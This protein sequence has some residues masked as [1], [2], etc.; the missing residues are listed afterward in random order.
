[1]VSRKMSNN[2][3][4]SIRLTDDTLARADR[5]VSALAS[6]PELSAA[7]AQVT[8]STVLRLAL[9]RGLAQL[10]Q[11][12]QQNQASPA[13]TRTGKAAPRRR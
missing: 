9:L 4:T 1:M 11:E 10:E 5:L 8:R 6:E 3:T 2:P 7:T 12:Q 13:T